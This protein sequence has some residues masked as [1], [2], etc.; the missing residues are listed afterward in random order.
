MPDQNHTKRVIS[1]QNMFPFTFPNPGCMVGSS[2]QAKYKG[3][4]HAIEK[5]FLTGS[6]EGH[7]CF[8]CRKGDASVFM[9]KKAL[10]SLTIFKRTTINREGKD[11]FVRLLW[12]L[13]KMI[14]PGKLMKGVLFPQNNTPACKSLVS[15][16]AIPDCGFEIVDQPPYS[17]DL[18][19]FG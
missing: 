17:P 19:P 18:A 5:P 14:C 11:K 15:M 7:G 6:K 10:Y 13:I 4:I 8:I 16:V 9:M 1:D 2:I 12:E 3:T